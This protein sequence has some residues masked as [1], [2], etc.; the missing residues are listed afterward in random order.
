MIFLLKPQHPEAYLG[1]LCVHLLWLQRKVR[2]RDLN[3]RKHIKMTQLYLSIPIVLKLILR[4]QKNGGSWTICFKHVKKSALLLE[5]Q[6]TC[7]HVFA[8]VVSSYHCEKVLIF[9]KWKSPSELWQVSFWSS[10]YNFVA[11]VALTPS[12]LPSMCSDMITYIHVYGGKCKRS[13]KEQYFLTIHQESL[14]VSRR[15][16]LCSF[17]FV[18]NFDRQIK[19]IIR[20]QMKNTANRPTKLYTAGFSVLQ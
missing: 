5:F 13:G 7:K 4:L 3:F 12:V 17:L 20:L 15:S 8:L 10:F 2:L 19:S 14:C 11:S 16:F 18:N 9:A 1:L 6:F